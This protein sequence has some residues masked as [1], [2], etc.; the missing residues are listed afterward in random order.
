MPKMRKEVSEEEFL[1]F[2]H[3]YLSEAFSRPFFKRSY[4]RPVQTCAKPNIAES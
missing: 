1:N 4:T 2:A 3:S